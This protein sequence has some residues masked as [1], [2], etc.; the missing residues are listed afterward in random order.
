MHNPCTIKT[1]CRQW[2][3]SEMLVKCVVS[4]VEHG[5]FSLIRGKSLPRAPIKCVV[6]DDGHLMDLCLL[7]TDHQA[8]LS[9]NTPV[10]NQSLPARGFPAVGELW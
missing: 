10:H 9:I 7:Y 3:Q 8:F 1:G 4:V 6:L 5:G 2:T